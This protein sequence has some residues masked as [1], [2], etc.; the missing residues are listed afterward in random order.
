[1]QLK[2]RLEITIL[3]TGLEERTNKGVLIDVGF[4]EEIR[5]AKVGSGP[6]KSFAESVENTT[7]DVRKVTG[8]R[9]PL[10]PPQYLVL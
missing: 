3:K 5:N 9:R 6:G 2:S 8:I 1:M 7:G 10:N 4:N